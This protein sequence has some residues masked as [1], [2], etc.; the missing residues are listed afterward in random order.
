MCCVGFFLQ[1]RQAS[2]LKP[3]GLESGAL[4][5]ELRSLAIFWWPRRDSNPNFRYPDSKALN[6]LPY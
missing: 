4:P 2:N 6:A 3:P 1:E 5:I